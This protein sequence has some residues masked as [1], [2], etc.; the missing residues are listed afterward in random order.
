M[1]EVQILTSIHGNR[2]GITAE[3]D[4]A[5]Q[6]PANAEINSITSPY[7][8][9]KR[10]FKQITSAQL[11]ALNATP[12]TVVAAP[13]AGRAI[14]PTRVNVYKP[15]GTAY[16]G[17]AAGEDL[18]LKYTNGSGAQCSSVIEATG[19]LDQTTAQ[20][21]SAGAPASTGS[22]AGD[23]TPVANAAVVMHMLTGEI[24]TGDQPIYVEVYY[25]EI[26][27]VFTA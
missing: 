8:V 21:R 20:I 4:L 12:I 15:A 1:A 13:G 24:T 25:N 19:F 16:A 5:M 7:I 27:T 14:V 22:T 17:I 9:Q 26:K 23:I 18:V 3:G 6:N 10:A 2:I 11:L